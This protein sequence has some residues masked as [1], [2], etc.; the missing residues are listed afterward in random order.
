M[1]LTH[2]HELHKRRFSRNVGLGVV[3]GAFVVLIFFLT[4][5][6]VTQQ[7][8]QFPDELQQTQQGGN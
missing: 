1:P 4:F 7:N 2:E 6:K 3:L 5:A 8:I